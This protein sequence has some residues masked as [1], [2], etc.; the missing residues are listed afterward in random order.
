M[1]PWFVRIVLGLKIANG[2]MALTILAAGSALFLS[3]LA[4]NKLPTEPNSGLN[5]DDSLAVLAILQANHKLWSNSGMVV[6]ANSFGQA[7]YLGLSGMELDTIPP[8]IGKLIALTGI[9]LS[10]NQLRKLPQ[11][12]EM[13]TNLVKLDL[14]RNGFDSLPDGFTLSRLQHL[15]VS[16]NRLSALPRNVD[17]TDLRDLMLDSNRIRA[18]PPDFRYLG[19]LEIFSIQGNL[20]DSLPDS[21]G[22]AAHPVLKRLFLTDNNLASLPPGMQDFSLEYLNLARNRLCLPDT[23]Q[24]D[25]AQR[26]LIDWLDVADRDWRATQR[27]P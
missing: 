12:F 8:D 17:V 24:A 1:T 5:P 18:L 20:L 7:E 10:H 22:P 4:C 16:H 2:V 6:N 19:K 15:D 23:A 25:S 21:F 14:S 26:A 13:L 27:C 9:D 11:E 3:S